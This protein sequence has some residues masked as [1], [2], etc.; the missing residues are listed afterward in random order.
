MARVQLYLDDL[1]R[2]HFYSFTRPDGTTDEIPGLRLKVFVNLMQLVVPGRRAGEAAFPDCVLDTGAFLSIVPAYIWQQ[3]RPGV[4]TPL[5][6]DPATPPGHRFLTIAGGRYAYELGEITA[7]LEDPSRATMDVT[8]IAKF[9]RDGGRLTIPLTL[10][11]RGGVL[12]GR[13]LHAEPDPTA[14]HTQ[15]WSLADP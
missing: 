10:G 6:F 13:V 7:R 2:P 12:D 15:A 3:F 5:P 8:L 14:P 11:L 1:S 4:I 9:T